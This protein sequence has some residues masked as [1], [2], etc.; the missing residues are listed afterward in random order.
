[1][2]KIESQITQTQN[3]KPCLMSQRCIC[4]QLLKP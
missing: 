3:Y 4:R 2:S 1:M